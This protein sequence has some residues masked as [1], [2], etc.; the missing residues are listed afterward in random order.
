M[1]FRRLF[2]AF[3]GG[4]FLVSSL[5]WSA[6]PKKKKKKGEEEVT[7]VL[8]VPKDPPAWTV[9]DA[10]R[11]VFH[12]SP[13]SAKGLLSQQT[14]DAL[15][16]VMGQLRGA[17]IV[18]IRAF[19]AGSAD[20]RRVPAIVSEELTDRRMAL[21]TV[22][23]VQVGALPLTG[24]Q[25]QLE[26]TSVEKK[27]VNPAG[28]A[29]ISGQGG[30]TADVSAPLLK[31]LAGAS[32]PPDGVR[33][34]TCFMDSLETVE[35]AR[36][37][38]AE[39]FP[40]APAS[41]VQLRRDSA[42]DFVECEAVAALPSPLPAS[43]AFM[44]NVEN[45]YSQVVAVGPGRIA[46]TGIQLGF[47]REEGDVKLAFERLGKTLESAGTGFQHVVM[48]SVYPLTGR[49]T[50][51]IRKIRTSYYNTSNPPASTLLTFEGL[52]SLDASFGID[53]VA[54]MPGKP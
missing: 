2:A 22:T 44:G 43:P 24:A 8:E 29:F 41:F 21:P 4:L 45:R 36:A 27:P 5:G 35:K 9:A 50:E 32:L 49:V 15:K 17:Q 30:T 38:L 48:S 26:T 1:P 34:V 23:V 52:A 12:V 51:Q 39:Q 6:Q 47:G 14:R 18:K 19:V 54:L 11:L 46:L 3:V 20:L 40:K 33:R 13:L 16:A 28:V 53:V 7:Q 31:A 42:G 37:K 10:S 25:V